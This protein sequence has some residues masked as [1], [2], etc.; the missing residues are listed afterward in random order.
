M[1]RNKINVEANEYYKEIEKEEI[2]SSKRKKEETL[3][4]S[5]EKTS[6]AAKSENKDFFEKVGNGAKEIG[7]KI[8]GG[9]KSIS[10]KIVS[11]AKGIGTKIKEG[12]ERLFSKDKSS[13][14]ESKEAKLLRLLPYMSKKDAHNL[15][16]EIMASDDMLK[17]INAAEIMPFISKSDCDMLFLKCIENSDFSCDVARAVPY[18]SKKCLSRVVD[19]YINGKYPNLDMDSMYPFLSDEEIKKIFYSI[20]GER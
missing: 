17:K 14:P 13:N 19:D 20:I 1:K 4:G 8:V 2:S 18:V 11:G 5:E 16:R 6:E 3:G 9:A 15:C 7:T 10:G 12:T